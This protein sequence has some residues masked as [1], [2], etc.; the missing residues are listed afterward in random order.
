MAGRPGGER[1]DLVLSA[2]RLSH[3][4]RAAASL[5]LL[6]GRPAGGSGAPGPAPA[7]H[8]ARGRGRPRGAQRWLKKMHPLKGQPWLCQLLQGRGRDRQPPPLQARMEGRGPPAFPLPRDGWLSSFNTLFWPPRGPAFAPAAPLPGC[9][10]PTSCIPTH[11]P[12]TR[13]NSIWTLRLRSRV[14]SSRKPSR[15]CSSHS[16]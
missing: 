13:L 5:H 12:S 1:W 16:S 11:V 15:L 10:P 6:R 8:A 14:P 4:S 7:S 2:R 3:G 9:S